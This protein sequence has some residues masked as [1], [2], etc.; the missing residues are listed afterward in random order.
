ME[1]EYLIIGQGIAG[2]MIAFE[3][4][5]RSVSFDIINKTD[6]NSS[7][8]VAAG[9]YNPITGRKMVKTWNADQ[10]FSGLEHYYEELERFLRGKFLYSSKIY[11]PFLSLEEQNDWQGR[12]GDGGFNAFV[13]EVKS[14]KS[15]N[16][17]INDSFGGLYL[18][19]AGYVDTT[20]MLESF[21][22]FF[23]ELGAYQED[24]FDFSQ[25]EE[26]T[27][28]FLYRGITYKGVIFCE[29]NNVRNNPYFDWLPLKP[30][31]GEILDINID[32]DES[33]ILNRGVFMLPKTA[34]GYS[35]VGSTYDNQMLNYEPTAVALEYL[36][37]KLR[38][39]YT[40]D[41]KLVRHR[42]GIRPATRDRKPFVG[43]HPDKKEL[44]IFN[45][46]GTKGVSLAVYYA[47]QFADYLTNEKPIDDEVNI[48]RFFSFYSN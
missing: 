1:K 30:V 15:A 46:L 24:S 39:I 3:L 47:K 11:R 26:Q 9:L 32:Y 21:K 19:N 7:S 34:G 13:E 45:G 23:L 29:G 36:T 16:D 18:K 28:A 27:N 31:K 43:R 6:Y 35:R 20:V 33:F 14:G 41:F 4:H 38:A 42:A 40:R 37:E 5:Q 10:I 12:L 48:E 22:R 44:T 17:S 8:H 2:S 25:L